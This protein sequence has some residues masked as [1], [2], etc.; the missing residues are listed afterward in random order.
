VLLPT[1]AAT[2]TV[3]VTRCAVRRPA[4][5]L[6]DRRGSAWARSRPSRAALRPPRRV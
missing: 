4:W 6:R 3:R 1:S 5:P 2:V